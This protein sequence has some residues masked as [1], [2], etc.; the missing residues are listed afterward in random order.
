M[1]NQ[2]GIFFIWNLHKLVFPSTSTKTFQV[3]YQLKSEN[4]RIIPNKMQSVHWFIYFQCLKVL[5]KSYIILYSK[6]GHMITIRLTR[7]I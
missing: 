4:Y 7:F 6:A 2:T 1:K 5:I 3:K